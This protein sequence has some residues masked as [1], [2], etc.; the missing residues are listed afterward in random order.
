MR[1][2]GL[3]VLLR[4]YDLFNMAM[5]PLHQT[6]LIRLNSTSFDINLIANSDTSSNPSTFVVLFP[7]ENDVNA[8]H[9]PGLGGVADPH[10]RRL[11]DSCLEQFLDD[12]V[13][14]RL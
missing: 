9:G 13:N 5:N 12:V 2:V 11:G 10:R 7:L 1:L 4:H 3:S 14:I 8:I 6:Q